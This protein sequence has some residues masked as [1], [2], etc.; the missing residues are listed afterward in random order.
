MRCAKASPKAPSYYRG[1]GAEII[2]PY[3]SPIGEPVRALVMTEKLYREK[4]EVAA[5]MLEC[6]VAATK[7]F[8][9][10]PAAAE[11][12]VCASLFKN[13]LSVKD[14]RETMDNAQFTYEITLE[15]VQKT[16]SMMKQ[17]GVFAG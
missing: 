4:P 13:S 7:K 16:S 6:F 10:D 2:K 5:R 15:H 14:Y 11:S 17:Y 1:F 8:I 9:E 3:D 12:Y